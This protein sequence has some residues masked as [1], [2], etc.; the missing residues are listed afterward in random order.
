M[1]AVHVNMASC[2]R[3]RL[4]TVGDQLLQPH[5][6][7]DSKPAHVDLG[8]VSFLCAK[9]ALI[10]SFLCAKFEK[11]ATQTATPVAICVAHFF[12][13]SFLCA[14][15]AKFALC[16]VLVCKVRKVCHTNGRL[17]GTHL[18]LRFLC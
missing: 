9:F 10:V 15:F 18:S 11:C 8:L 12:S 17:C 13:V 6:Q 2:S 3:V 16:E 4:F 1:A 5:Q 7:P 14:K